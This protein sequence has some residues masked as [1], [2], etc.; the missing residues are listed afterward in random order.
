VASLS[1]G[2]SVKADPASDALGFSRHRTDA[3]G[4]IYL[5]AGAM[6][7][8]ASVGRTLAPVTATSG[9]LSLTGGVTINIAGP[10]AHT[11]RVP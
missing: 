1:H 4:G 10:A 8:F 9:R 5:S 6:V 7:F 3:S 2:Y 11:P